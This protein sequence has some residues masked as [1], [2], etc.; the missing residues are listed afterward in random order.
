VRGGTELLPDEMYLALEGVVRLIVDRRYE[1]LSAISD[2]RLAA[3]DIQR[4]IEDD[5]PLPARHAAA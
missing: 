1:E 3:E 5:Y 4:C 2:G